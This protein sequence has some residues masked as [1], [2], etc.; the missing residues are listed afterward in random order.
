MHSLTRN[1]ADAVGSMLWRANYAATEGWG[2]VEERAVPE[3]PSYV[4]E[5]L[6]GRADPLIVLSAVDCY[7]Y[8]TS[9][10]PDE[11]EDTLVFG[12]THWLYAAAAMRLPCRDDAPW[13]I[14]HRDVFLHGAGGGERSP[15]PPS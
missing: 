2:R 13:P 12:F 15:E 10:E 5:E 6:P 7:L 14:E 3:M 8:Q 9:G 4:F 1:N 11:F